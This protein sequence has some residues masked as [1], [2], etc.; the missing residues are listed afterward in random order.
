MN[1]A[2]DNMDNKLLK[3]LSHKNGFFIEAGANDGISQSNT[4]LFEFNHSWTGLLVE[5]SRIKYE[6]AVKNRPN[7]IVE[8]YALVSSRYKGKFVRGDF[9]ESG[10]GHGLCSMVIDDKENREYYDLDL[11]NAE[12]ERINSNIVEVPC[13]TVDKLI[14]KHNIQKIDLFSLDVESYEEDVLNGIDFSL[15]RPKY[16]LIEVSYPGRKKSITDFMQSKNY[17]AVEQLGCHDIL[18]EDSQDK[19]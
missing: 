3:Y 11:E 2:L 1:Y 9:I 18:F 7:S 4:A 13:I 15:V 12:K 5:P 10:H 16:F 8:N 17:Q 6:Q 14:K 19:G